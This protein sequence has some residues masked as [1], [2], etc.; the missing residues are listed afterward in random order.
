MEGDAVEDGKRA[1]VA[2]YETSQA[3]E[4]QFEKQVDPISSRATG[5]PEMG[6]T[7]RLREARDDLMEPAL[8]EAKAERERLDAER[9]TAKEQIQEIVDA[10]GKPENQMTTGVIPPATPEDLERNQKAER[11][12][13][14]QPIMDHTRGPT[15]TGIP[16][17]DRAPAADRAATLETSRTKLLEGTKEDLLARAAELEISGR[18]SMNKEDL[19]AAIAEA[20]NPEPYDAVARR[21][22]LEELTD[23]ELRAAAF[24]LDVENQDQLDR[25][26]L[27]TQILAAE[28]TEA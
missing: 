25:E 11:D 8:E 20:E 23:D 15:A 24:D 2:A 14:G 16:A 4:L 18:S 10:G 6:P 5:V 9:E 19:A 3:T 27:I 12:E 21:T 1:N 22:E 28:Q 7:V 13:Q 26:G 17:T